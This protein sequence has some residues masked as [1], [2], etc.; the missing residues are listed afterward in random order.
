MLLV[1]TFT[2][3]EQLDGGLHL[4]IEVPLIHAEVLFGLIARADADPRI[5]G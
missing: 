3:S 2:V 4:L 1:F 5:P